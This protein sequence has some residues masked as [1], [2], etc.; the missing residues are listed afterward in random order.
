M[1]IHSR[2]IR[3][4]EGIVL[5]WSIEPSSVIWSH[6]ELFLQSVHQIWVAGKVST[7]QQRI[8]FTRFHYSPGVL[9]IPSTGGEERSGAKDL[10]ETIQGH[11]QQAPA[12]EELIL[13][14]GPEDLFKTLG[15]LAV[16]H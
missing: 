12:F 13:L 6:G 10:A 7:I 1:L 14:F 4:M 8:V 11:A 9:I 16:C 5:K 3:V 15:G 2:V